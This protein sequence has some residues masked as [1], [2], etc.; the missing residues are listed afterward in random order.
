MMVFPVLAF[1]QKPSAQLNE[2]YHFVEAADSLS[3]RS[4]SVFYL[5]KFY[6]DNTPYKETWRYT[7][8]AGKVIFF[9]VEFIRDSVT[10]SEVYY[11]N[12]NNLVCSEEYEIMNDQYSDDKLTWGAIFYFNSTQTRHYVTVGKSS[13]RKYYHSPEIVARDRFRKRFGELKTHLP[14]LP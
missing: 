3:D 2:L 9:E 13:S 4:N 8:K 7:T 6:A 1:G 12:R 14:M 11:V 5:D 10:Y